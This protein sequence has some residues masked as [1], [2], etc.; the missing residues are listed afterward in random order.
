MENKT[1]KQLKKESDKS[2]KFLSNFAN[3]YCKDKKGKKEFFDAL[4]NYVEL[5]VKIEKEFVE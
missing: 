5:E 2:F 4:S 1:Y 3:D